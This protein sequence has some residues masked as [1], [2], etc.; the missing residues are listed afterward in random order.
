MSA[1][2]GTVLTASALVSS[3]VLWL[4]QEGTLTPTDAVQRWAVCVALCWVAITV[5]S[6]FAFPDATRSVAPPVRAETDE[7]DSAEVP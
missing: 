5:V 7:P 3:P 4:L 6:A 2:L 1:S